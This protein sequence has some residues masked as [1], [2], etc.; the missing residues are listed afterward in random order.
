MF[1]DF[2]RFHLNCF[3]VFTICIFSCS[4]VKSFA[5]NSLENEDAA[6]VTSEV[7]E[8]ANSVVKP[9][10]ANVPNEDKL[11]MLRKISE[12]IISR[13]HGVNSNAVEPS[14]YIYY[15]IFDTLK[16]GFLVTLNLS[17][18]QKQNIK[19]WHAKYMSDTAADVFFAPSASEII[20]DRAA[21]GC[22]H[23]ARVFI[24]V[25]KE[26]KIIDNPGDLRYAATCVAKDY[27]MA[28]KRQ[29][30]EMTINGHQF[31]MVRIGPKWYAINTS[32]GETVEMS[33]DFSPDKISPPNNTAIQFQSY[34]EVTFL[35]RK[36]GK[37]HSDNIQD[38]SL[39]KLMNIY[40]SGENNRQSFSWSE[41]EKL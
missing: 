5:N 28:Y 38:N 12:I 33:M 31:A 40:R 30:Y 21:F 34:P 19:N 10:I 11:S 1:T 26:L 16:L 27:N 29:D 32:K 6:I 25:V 35:F 15:D 3:S 39:I 14:K 24:A 37:N 20:K 41:Y 23:Y 18:H 7:E 2:I 8:Y 22:T 9:L 36:I 17:F 4:C 13:E